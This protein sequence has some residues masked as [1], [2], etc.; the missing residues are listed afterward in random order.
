MELMKKVVLIGIDGMDFNLFE[1]WQDDLPNLKKIYRE[2]TGR[3][4]ESIFPPD[5]ISAW[6]T[7]FTGLDPSEHGLLYSID[8]LSADK[9]LSVNT[10]PF[11]DKTFWDTLGRSGKRVCVVNPFM[12][13]PPWEVNG[14]MVSGPVFISG[15]VTSF[16]PEI[17]GH[18]DL[19]EMGG[20]VDFPSKKD[21]GSFYE[22]AK[23]S[24]RDL[25]EYGLKLFQKE[26]WDLF[27]ISFLTLD[28]VKHFMWRY[29]DPNDPTY[30][31]P[32]PFEQSIK[33]FYVLFDTIIGE[34]SAI[35]GQDT[36]VM[37]IS[38]HGHQKRCYRII[39]M[40]EFL[41]RKQYLK[42]NIPQRKYFSIK[43]WIEKSKSK[44]LHFISD[45]NL[46]DYA[47]K[48]IKY[49]P[50]K[51]DLKKSSYITSFENSYAFT[52]I[53]F[54]GKNPNAG[55]RLNRTKI[56]RDHLVYEEVRERVMRDIEELRDPAGN[57]S[58]VSWVKKREDLFGGKY[59]ER[60]PDILIQLEG[61]YGVDFELFGDLFSNSVTHKKISGGHTKYGVLFLSGPPSAHLQRVKNLRDVHSLVV[62]L[63]ET[64]G[65]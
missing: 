11:R 4:L 49:I 65:P 29:Q 26:R 47:K 21:L 33:E 17:A 35:A 8:Y 18:G 52:D 2:G 14:V 40:N 15:S 6:T 54:S 1:R 63:V 27:F 53:K 10:D 48:I 58:V 59:I 28:R 31:G 12:A 60:Y 36:R 41:R 24:T 9:T 51:S 5:S 56:E 32:N 44:A 43:Y 37:V 50:R 61:N 55:I 34:Y 30:P 16:P 45:H 23:Q 22:K 42:A 20:I 46:E 62:T 38:D 13:Y 3:P 39:N 19:P 25:A 57:H 7:I 64:E